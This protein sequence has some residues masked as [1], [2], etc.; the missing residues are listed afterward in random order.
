MVINSYVCIASFPIFSSYFV[1]Y[2]ASLVPSFQPMVVFVVT[3][4][5]M[6]KVFLVL[7]RYVSGSMSVLELLIMMIRRI[8]NLLD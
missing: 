5:A 4:K 3:F 2:T 8:Q 7:A 1:R 6:A